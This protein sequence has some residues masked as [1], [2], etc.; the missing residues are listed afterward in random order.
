MVR[1]L[2]QRDGDRRG[3][4]NTR[5]RIDAVTRVF[6]ATPRTNPAIITPQHNAGVAEW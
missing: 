4:L 5:H 6:I 1:A 2:R 3:R